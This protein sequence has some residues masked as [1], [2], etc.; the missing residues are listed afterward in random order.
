MERY[1]IRKKKRK[2][3]V[4]VIKGDLLQLAQRGKFD[5]IA[6]GC[7]CQKKMGAG[8]ARKIA[9]KWPQAY[10][11]DLKMGG[12]LGKLT[13]CDVKVDGGKSLRIFNLYTQQF[14]GR[15]KGHCYFDYDAFKSSLEMMCEN[16]DEHSTVGL[17]LIGTGLAGGERKKIVQ[18]ITETLGEKHYITIVEFGA[19]LSPESERS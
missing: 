5:A 16:L 7:N 14:Y 4:R 15:K 6:H 8:I 17:P 12:K 9:S 3:S 1:L 10:S 13:F 11:I 19:L 18:I 2:T